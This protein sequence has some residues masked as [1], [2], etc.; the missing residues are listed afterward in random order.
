M[1]GS[2]SL[3]TYNRCVDV[4]GIAL[5][6]LASCWLSP[7]YLS[8]FRRGLTSNSY[9]TW[10][11]VALA[12]SSRHPTAATLPPPARSELVKA[13]EDLREQR[14]EVNRG[15][16]RDEEEKVRWEGEGP[17]CAAARAMHAARS[18]CAATADLRPRPTDR[19]RASRRS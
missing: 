9:L 14:E 19:R 10:P 18:R 7:A 11:A 2:A 12:S 1:A 4:P 17:A 6:L 8:Q 5:A 3:T 13:L 15:I 16:L